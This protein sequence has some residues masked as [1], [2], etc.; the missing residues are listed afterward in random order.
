[1]ANYSVNDIE[2]IGV[3]IVLENGENTKGEILEVATKN[4]N[5]DSK[6]I[7]LD[8]TVRLLDGP[9]EGKD[10][11]LFAGDKVHIP[12]L[13]S[14]MTVGQVQGLLNNNQGVSQLVGKHVM[15]RPLVPGESKTTG[16]RFTKL[17]GLDHLG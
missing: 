17:G 2:N 3:H 11:R 13:S 6:K 14:I 4:N 10:I 15:L 9:H 8:M 5:F 16:R 1:M 7:D 12:F